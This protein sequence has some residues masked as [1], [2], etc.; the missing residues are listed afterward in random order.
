MKAIP[1]RKFEMRR[2]NKE[3]INSEYTYSKSG[4]KSFHKTMLAGIRR[5]CGLSLVETRKK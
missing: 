2:D 4:K 1:Y 5:I 3:V